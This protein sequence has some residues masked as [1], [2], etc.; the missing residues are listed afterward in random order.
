M[1]S[2]PP[3]G[4][5]WY[6]IRDAAQKIGLPAKTIRNMCT[7]HLID[8]SEIKNPITGT[9]TKHLIHETTIQHFINQH[10]VPAHKEHQR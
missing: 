7:A 2:Q 10:Y 8:H 4:G 5:T 1:T 6:T 3:V 9:V